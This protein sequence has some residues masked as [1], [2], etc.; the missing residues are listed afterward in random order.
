[1]EGS[2]HTQDG[3][4]EEEEREREGEEVGRL[5]FP[6]LAQGYP[7]GRSVGELRWEGWE[8]RG[9]ESAREERPFNAPEERREAAGARTRMLEAHNAQL[10]VEVRN[11]TEQLEL[12]RRRADESVR[13]VGGGEGRMREIPDPRRAQQAASTSNSTAI[14]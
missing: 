3:R 1:M 11:L 6:S 2:R 4:C 13:V 8:P 14:R 9:S 12:S 10:E 5:D 7:T